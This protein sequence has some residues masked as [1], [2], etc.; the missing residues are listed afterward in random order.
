[1]TV[2]VRTNPPLVML[3]VAS[4]TPEVVVFMPDPFN[5]VRASEKKN[6]KIMATMPQFDT[7]R[8][9]DPV[10]YEK[11]QADVEKWNDKHNSAFSV[12]I[13][14][15]NE[16]AMTRFIQGFMGDP[17]AA[18]KTAN[19]KGTRFAGADKSSCSIS[20][21]CL[22]EGV[23]E[24]ISAKIG[25]KIRWEVA[26]VLRYAVAIRDELAKSGVP[27]QNNGYQGAKSGQ[28]HGPSVHE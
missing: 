10:L 15:M 3:R 8:P 1:M 12:F 2:E 16:E 20:A 28:L 25:V 13:D 19:F 11:W 17:A 23:P 27:Q 9:F 5:E 6:A 21:R 24:R 18:T 26:D 7:N 14:G 22:K 4:G